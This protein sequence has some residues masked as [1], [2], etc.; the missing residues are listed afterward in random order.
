MGCWGKVVGR[1]LESLVWE[2]AVGENLTDVWWGG[3]NRM[4]R[5]K[6]GSLSVLVDGDDPRVSK[7]RWI[8]YGSFHHSGTVEAGWWMVD[9]L[10]ALVQLY[11]GRR[12]TEKS[13]SL[14]AL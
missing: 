1:G 5:A 3:R 8:R 2:S 13:R 11:V 7:S 4:W 6:G 10:E 9:L 12:H 14:M